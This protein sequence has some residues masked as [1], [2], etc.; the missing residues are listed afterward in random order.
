MPSGKDKTKG[1]ILGKQADLD[2]RV[3]S[4]FPFHTSL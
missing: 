4:T 2:R 3:L 1:A